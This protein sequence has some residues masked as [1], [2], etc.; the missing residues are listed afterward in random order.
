MESCT[1]GTQV[2][3]PSLGD[4]RVEWGE[5]FCWHTWKIPCKPCGLHKQVI[6]HRSHLHQETEWQGR[7]QL[8]RPH[9]FPGILVSF[10]KALKSLNC[11]CTYVHKHTNQPTIHPYISALSSSALTDGL[12]LWP[13]SW[14]DWNNLCKSQ[15][16]KSVT[17]ALPGK[18][19]TKA[20]DRNTHL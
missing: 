16:G 1:W 6:G 8:A 2:T 5:A 3:Q 10:R 4:R 14:F 7:H 20:E 15:F 13:L 9:S 11:V 17:N 19:A 12:L 18:S